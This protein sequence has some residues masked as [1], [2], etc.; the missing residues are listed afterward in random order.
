MTKRDGDRQRAGRHNAAQARPS[1]ARARKQPGARRL[2]FDPRLADLGDDV[3]R[4]AEEG[5]PVGAPLR[6]KLE[7]GIDAG[8]TDL[9]DDVALPV[10][11]DDEERPA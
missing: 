6:G 1:E 4:G 2:T 5:G 7:G 11:L 10:E 3:V 8:L 9:G